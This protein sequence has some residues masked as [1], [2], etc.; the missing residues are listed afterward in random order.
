MDHPNMF[1]VGFSPKQMVQFE[2]I[3]KEM[4]IPDMQS[5]ILHGLT[6]VGL[7]GTSLNTGCEM[8]LINKETAKILTTEDGKK[9]AVIGTPKDIKFITKEIK[10]SIGLVEKIK[11][12]NLGLV[13]TD[14]GSYAL[15]N[16]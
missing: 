1:S 14:I 11:E 7:V 16:N 10:E 12:A 15:K 13:I 6:L 3:C 9:I 2:R 8:A 4:E 5:L